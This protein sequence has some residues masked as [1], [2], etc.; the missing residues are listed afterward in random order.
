MKKI[1]FLVLSLIMMFAISTAF[2]NITDSVQDTEELPTAMYYQ[3]LDK[4]LGIDSIQIVMDQDIP[5]EFIYF[6]NGTIE[7][8]TPKYAHIECIT[9][10][11]A[12]LSHLAINS[13]LLQRLNALERT[14]TRDVDR[15]LFNAFLYDDAYKPLTIE[16]YSN[17]ILTEE[18]Q[19]IFKADVRARTGPSYVHLKEII[20]VTL[21]VLIGYFI[22]SYFLHKIFY[23]K[24]KSSGLKTG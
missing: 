13:G 10:R 9:L 5:L 21:L 11:M 16:E 1:H 8:F 15:V 22:I 2:M 14:S 12:Y 23:K 7:V 6:T 19:K 4:S 17:F 20:I 18:Q 3:H 24:S